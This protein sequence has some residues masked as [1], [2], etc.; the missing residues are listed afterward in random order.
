[1]GG[2]RRALREAQVAPAAPAR[3][4][5]RALQH[6][7]LALNEAPAP[8]SRQCRKPRQGGAF[9]F[10]PRREAAAV[11]RGYSGYAEMP[12][13]ISSTGVGLVLEPNA[14]RKIASIAPLS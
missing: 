10:W 5:A 2:A 8:A 13:M 7:P 1:A 9:R 12:Y 11:R 14:L 6:E 3:A 4:Q